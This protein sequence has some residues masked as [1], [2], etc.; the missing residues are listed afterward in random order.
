MPESVKVHASKRTLCEVSD[1]IS[2][3]QESAQGLG[4]P[5]PGYSQGEGDLVAQ[6]QD[7]QASQLAKVWSDREEG[8]WLWPSDRI[9]SVVTPCREPS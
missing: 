9:H 2:I 3:Q 1:L 6:H 5:E 7:L 4:V 8:M